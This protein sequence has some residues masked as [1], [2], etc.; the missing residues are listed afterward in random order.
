MDVGVLSHYVHLAFLG[1]DDMFRTVKRAVA[2]AI[3]VM[4]LS[5]SVSVEAQVAQS[6]LTNLRVVP[7]PAIEGT[8]VFA[9]L[10]LDSQC[11][12][13][14]PGPATVTVQGQVV[15]LR[16]DFAGRG[17]VCIGVPPLRRD[18][19]IPIGAYSV[20]VYTLVYAPVNGTFAFQ[21]QSVQFTVVGAPSVVPVPTMSH[22]S[23]LALTVALG[24]IALV[25]LRM[26]T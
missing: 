24:G 6:Y 8:T 18:I 20:G 26:P 13:S 9:R 25:R 5:A 1:A 11:L 3:V 15:T 23:L 4:G 7:S 10:L 17:G 21:T 16:H 19:D 2:L 12:L 14:G 22:W